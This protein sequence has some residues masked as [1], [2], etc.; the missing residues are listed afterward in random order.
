MRSST[1]KRPKRR[2]NDRLSAS[3]NFLNLFRLEA[4]IFERVFGA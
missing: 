1:R 4:A 2:K 3:L